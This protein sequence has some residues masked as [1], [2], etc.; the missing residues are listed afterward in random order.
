VSFLVPARVLVDVL[1]LNHRDGRR[2]VYF[3]C[4]YSFANGGVRP[5]MELSA[6]TE[7]ISDWSN[8]V[9]FARDAAE[10]SETIAASEGAI[11]VFEVGLD[12]KSARRAEAAS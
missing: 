10:K 7:E 2:V 11:A 8:F 3:E 4:L 1:E 5:S 9:A 12:Q 6:T